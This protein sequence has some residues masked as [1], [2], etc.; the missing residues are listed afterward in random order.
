MTDK[1]L[2]NMTVFRKATR[3][4]TLYELLA[5]ELGLNPLE[6]TTSWKDIAKGYNLTM[7]EA[8]KLQQNEDNESTTD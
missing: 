6:P 4:A 3:C 1:Q 2:E 7:E 5:E 8:H